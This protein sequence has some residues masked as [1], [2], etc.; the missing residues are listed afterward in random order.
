MSMTPDTAGFADAQERLRAALGVDAT[1]MIPVAATWDP[2]EPLDPETGRPYDPFATALT[3]G[4]F[5]E[6][7]IRV[8]F[9]S[10][11]LGST[12]SATGE[13]G[14]TPAGNIDESVAALIVAAEDYDSVADA[15]RV[16]VNDHEWQIEIVRHDE[17]A[18]R[19]RWIFFLE[20][21]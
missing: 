2:D 16:V 21:A 19:K 10:R 20:D 7:V 1:F 18:G 3:G 9:V 5:D 14:S 11:P 8:S 17:L 15:T 13:F 6:V 12:R 4:G